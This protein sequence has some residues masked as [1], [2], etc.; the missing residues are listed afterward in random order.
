MCVDLLYEVVGEVFSVYNWSFFFSQFDKTP[1]NFSVHIVS[2][3]Y[4]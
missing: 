2:S 4:L 3:V 1:Y